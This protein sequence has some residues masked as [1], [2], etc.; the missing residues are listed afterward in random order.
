MNLIF[1]LIIHFFCLS[2]CIS[3]IE[4][5]FTVIGSLGKE[6]SSRSSMPGCAVYLNT[7][8]F[9]DIE[10][11]DLEVILK[12]GDLSESVMYYGGNDVALPYGNSIT[13]SNI[14]TYYAFNS[15]Y[16]DFYSKHNYYYFK[17]PKLNDKYLYVS[18]PKFNGDYIEIKVV[19]HDSQ[20]IIIGI[21]IG[22][23]I[24]LIIIMIIVFIIKKKRNQNYPVAP[25]AQPYATNS[26][27]V[28]PIYPKNNLPIEPDYPS[29]IN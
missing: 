18:F 23:I 9:S 22:V 10:E 15:Y 26:T 3:F 13:L 12:E 6:G 11:I 25:P 19:D 1:F 7:N 16:D 14:R 27:N 20:G 17:I 29:S 28:T 4:K 8:E 5:N 2:H 24:F 21:I